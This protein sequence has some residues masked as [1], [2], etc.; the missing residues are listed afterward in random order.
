MC[1]VESSEDRSQQLQSASGKEGA[2]LCLLRQAL[3]IGTLE[4]LK[5]KNKV[6][7]FTDLIQDWCDIAALKGPISMKGS[8]K[9]VGDA[10]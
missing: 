6:C 5:K 3:K 4:L 7:S 2:A 9:G 10:N 8:C 1:L